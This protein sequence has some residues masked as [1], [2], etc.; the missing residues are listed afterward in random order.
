[1]KNL[2]THYRTCNLCEA[3]CGLVITTENNQIKTIIGDDRDPL[4]RGH[5]CPKALAYR[6]LHED[7]DRLKF[8]VKKT[9]SGWKKI[10]WEEAFETVA[11][12]LVETQDQYGNNAVGIYQGN[13]S[14]H[15]FGTLLYAPSL[16]R[17]LGTRNNY[18]AS[19]VDQI[20]HQFA[21]Y[22]MFGHQLLVPIPDI[23]HTGYMMIIGGNPLVSNGSLMT[24]P[25]VKNRL[26][27]IQSR[28]GQFIVVDPRKTET[29]KLADEHL[30]IQPGTDVYFMI[31][32][33]QEVINQGWIK[34][35]HLEKTIK[36]LDIFINAIPK[37]SLDAISKITG[38]PKNKIQ[39]TA[40]DFC[41]AK[42]AVCYGRMGAC[43]QK[44]GGTVHWLI[45]GLN[46]ITGNMDAIGGAMF[47]SPA[48]D[49]LA[50][51]ATRGHYNKGQSRV[52]NLPE[53]AGEYPAVTMADEMLVSGD[54]K[55]RAM[56]TSAGNPV[57]SVPGG[58]KLEKAF[59]ALD[60]M[61]S[62]DFYINETT[63]YADIILPP[64]FNLNGGHFDIVFNIFSVRNIVKYSKA[65]FPKERGTKYDWEIFMELT[66]RIAKKKG[67]KYPILNH[68][69]T[70]VFGPEWLLDLGIRLGEYGSLKSIFNWSGLT[71]SKVKTQVNGVD[72][73]PLK[74]RFPNRLFTSDKKIDLAPPI[75]IEDLKRV[76]SNLNQTNQN[77][78]LTLIGRR[79]LRS[80]NSWM[81]N[82]PSLMSGSNR[83]LV[84]MNP[85]DGQSRL[86]NDGQKVKIESNN[87]VVE[88]D[89]KLTEEMMPGVISIPHGWGHESEGTQQ[90][91][92]LKNR[93]GN[94]NALGDEFAIDPVTGNAD[95]HIRNVEVTR[96]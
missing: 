44:F 52:R 56:V 67:N 76:N 86:I 21:A 3:M 7:P 66:Q 65:V 18:S 70:K 57:L 54:G 37:I 28:G 42:S 90:Q 74:P 48:L 5:I 20:P 38:I 47:T 92:A 19:T 15:N 41:H 34:E 23:D 88:L 46:I 45:N 14:V 33:I 81:H 58:K 64:A 30:F 77:S 83:F 60:F 22:Q 62:I 27:S 51:G 11:T 13:P 68:Y 71:L 75:F 24:A 82:C 80:N 89:A 17:S 29:A 78:S 36:N 16:T 50:S 10:T 69:L 26:K 39:E 9:D 87:F 8:P 49:T 4:S 61:V 40:K 93:G 6:D 91:T 25:D 2:K 73:G 43:T 95:L 85:K 12:R 55:I 63:R 53:F 84:L 32:L 94:L 96:L 72:L 31:G 79:Q 1:M 35:G 59:L